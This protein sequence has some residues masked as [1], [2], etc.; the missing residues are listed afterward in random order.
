MLTTHSDMNPSPPLPPS[1]LKATKGNAP[2]TMEEVTAALAL[3]RV[4]GAVFLIEPER[5][6]DDGHIKDLPHEL[7]IA[8]LTPICLPTLDIRSVV[9]LASVCKQFYSTLA[10]QDIWRQMAGMLFGVGS[11]SSS[12]SLGHFLSWNDMCLHR[13]RPLFHG[14]YITRYAYSRKGEQ[15]IGEW[16][17]PTHLV[18]YYRFLRFFP[19]GGVVAVTSSQV[20]QTIIPR[21]KHPGQLSEKERQ[22]LSLFSGSW[23]LEGDRLVV[24][25]EAQSN[26]N[27]LSKFNT[28]L[29]IGKRKGK[30][31]MKLEWEWHKGGMSR[32][33]NELL[34][35]DF[36]LEGFLPYTFSPVRNLPLKS[37]DRKIVFGTKGMSSGGGGGGDGGGGRGKG[38][39]G[40][41]KLGS[42]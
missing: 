36:D 14:V 17:R 13:P 19:N 39:G 18:E 15:T 38:G 32:E 27:T 34:Y 10:D 8:V 22:G 23:T 40:G 37:F 41:R 6:T 42:K 24:D 5:P 30:Q 11:S 21:L 9:R 33:G 2:A 29:R 16:Y 3:L 4:P 20:P 31:S 25:V 28:R 7:L 26:S 12:S 35:Q 1:P